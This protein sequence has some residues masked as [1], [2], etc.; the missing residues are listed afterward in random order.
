MLFRSNKKQFEFNDKKDKITNKEITQKIIYYCIPLIVISVTNDLYNIIDIKL[1]I[2]G[3]YII[4][5]NGSD[6]ELIAS[7]ISTWCPKICM[8][9]TAIS[10]GLATSL[11]PHLISSY[12][13]KDYKASNDIFSEAIS[14]MLVLSFP[15]TIG[16]MIL[17]KEV[18]CIFYGAST[19]GPDI[20][21]ISIVVSLWIGTL[22]VINT[23]LQGFKKFKLIIVSTIIGLVSNAVLDIPLILLLNK[24]NFKPYFGTSLATIIGTT[25]SAL[26]VLIY[27]KKEI[28]FSYKKIRSNAIKLIIPLIAM[29]IVVISINYLFPY[30]IN[31]VYCIVKCLIT[32]VIG[33]VIYF[34]ILSKNNGLYAIF[35]KERIDKI[36][37]KLHIK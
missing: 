36:Y 10:M 13:K 17:S 6:A 3:L 21:T 27:L 37:K 30:R 20:L 7:M 23:T 28:N 31:R 4:G 33:A 18:Y 11:M 25:I 8:I 15:L 12:T 24:L 22:T 29:T 1:I 26:I 14:M 5:M 2:K 16:I 32:G 19:Y 9:V 35:G 34:Y